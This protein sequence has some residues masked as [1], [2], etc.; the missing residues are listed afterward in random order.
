[1]LDK[2]FIDWLL[3]RCTVLSSVC[4][5]INKYDCDRITFDPACLPAKGGFLSKRT[6]V[7]TSQFIRQC[8]VNICCL[9]A[10]SRIRTGCV[11]CCFIAETNEDEQKG[12]DS[13]GRA[14]WVANNIVNL[15]RSLRYGRQQWACEHVLSFNTPTLEIRFESSLFGR[16]I[17]NVIWYFIY[18]L[19][20][21]PSTA[22]DGDS[23]I[24]LQ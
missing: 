11:R 16:D 3:S 5:S 7:P 17:V 24:Y 22:F 9:Y 18:C 12:D 20:T 15:T 14:V 10:S 19:L 2:S 1:M 4:L 8:F 6:Y 23:E 13:T 21:F